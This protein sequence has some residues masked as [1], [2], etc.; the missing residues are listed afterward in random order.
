MKEKLSNMYLT[1]LALFEK[2]KNIGEEWFN[3]LSE[4]VKE[5]AEYE[6]DVPTAIKSWKQGK[7]IKMSVYGKEQYLPTYKLAPFCG[8]FF[9]LL[10]EAKFYIV[11]GEDEDEKEFTDPYAL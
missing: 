7:K 6:V 4:L 11:E 9:A 2:D 5:N 8:V 3:R 10:D 1:D